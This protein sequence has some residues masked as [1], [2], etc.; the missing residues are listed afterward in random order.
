MPAKLVGRG[1]HDKWVARCRPGPGSPQPVGDGLLHQVL[2]QA[3]VVR[4][5]GLDQALVDAPGGLD[6][7]V[8]L[9]GD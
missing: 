6:R 9:A 5:V 3:R 1:G 8:A 2:S 7:S 4:P